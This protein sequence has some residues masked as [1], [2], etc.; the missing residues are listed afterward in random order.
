MKEIEVIIKRP[1]EKYGHK[2]RIQN[3]LTSFQKIVGGYIETVHV[4]TLVFICNEEG[5]IL[6]LEP[7]IRFDFLH[8]WDFFCGTIIVCGNDCDEF[9]DVPLS[10]DGWKDFVDSFGIRYAHEEDE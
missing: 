2:E 9:G 10:M 4:G 3:V 1:D 8:S 7:N 5:K 6:G